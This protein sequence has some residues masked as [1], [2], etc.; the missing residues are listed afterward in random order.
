MSK[1]VGPEP[2][3]DVDYSMDTPPPGWKPRSEFADTVR[4][5]MSP[6]ALKDAVTWDDLLDM[7]GIVV[8]GHSAVTDRIAMLQEEMRKVRDAPSLK[9]AG[10]WK[11]DAVY[12]AGTFTTDSGS[13][14]H[15][16]RASVGERP[17]AGDAWVLA[18]KKGRDAR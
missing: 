7:L 4:K 2:Q 18:V 5:A 8:E 9:Y 14:W 11:S 6:T 10:V 12:G 15:A 13:M 1:T 16:Q 17:G 3:M